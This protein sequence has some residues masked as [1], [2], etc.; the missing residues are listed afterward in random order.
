MAIIL[1]LGQIISLVTIT[2]M[3]PDPIIPALAM[4]L[5]PFIAT[6]LLQ[7]AGIQ[8][9]PGSSTI[10]GYVFIV[11]GISLI[12]VGQCLYQRISA[13]NQEDKD[14]DDELKKELKEIIA[15]KKMRQDK[16]KQRK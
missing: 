15:R 2:R 4:T 6:L 10:I 1:S 7:V 11:P 14:R 3:F 5:E 8:L 13:K 9:L 16:K 12:L